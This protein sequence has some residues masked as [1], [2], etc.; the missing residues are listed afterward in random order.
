MTEKKTTPKA[1]APAAKSTPAKSADATEAKPKTTRAKRK[2]P[3]WAQLATS[4]P[5]APA[6]PKDSVDEVAAPTATPVEAPTTTPVTGKPRVQKKA[7]TFRLPADCFAYIDRA[8]AV[9]A[10]NGDK[11]TND[12]I[13]TDAVRAWGKAWERK[14][15]E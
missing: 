14:H 13:V 5:S 4:A 9:A 6:A 1:K 8:K 15:G 3:N 2:S 11:L 12:M 7:Q 10:E